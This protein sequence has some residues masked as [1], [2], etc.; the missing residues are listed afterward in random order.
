MD[1]FLLCGIVY[2]LGSIPFGFIFSKIFSGKNL[3]AVGSGNVGASNALRTAGKGAAFLTLLFDVAKGYLAVEAASFVGYPFLGL[4]FVI[5][6]HLFPVWIKFRGGKGVATMFGAIVSLSPHLAIFT[7]ITWSGF[8][9]ITR[10]ASLASILTII[11][12][13]LAVWFWSISLPITTLQFILLGTILLVKHHSNIARLLKKK[14]K[15]I[16]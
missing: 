2:L 11:T 10:I 6:G 3:Y 13:C 14:E 7:A 8:L 4:L 15:A 12:T 5:L 1:P 16:I 9:I